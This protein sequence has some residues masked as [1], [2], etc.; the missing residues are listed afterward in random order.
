[1]LSGGRLIGFGAGDSGS[2]FLP[3]DIANLKA[4]Y[5]ADQGITISTGVSQW[6][7]LSG[8]ALHL[9]QGTGSNQ[10]TFDATGGP[11]STPTVKFDGSNDSLAV[12][13]TNVAQPYH[14]FAVF[15]TP[16]LANNLNGIITGAGTNERFFYNRTTNTMST[17]LNSGSVIL[18][19]THSDTSNYYLWEMKANSP[20]SSI[21]RGNG[22]PVTGDPGTQGISAIT[23]GRLVGQQYGACDIAEVIVYTALI[24]GTNATSIRAYFAARYGVTTQ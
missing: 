10:P 9:T 22:S 2:S 17:F 5:R 3:S 21:V 4:W 24:S 12:S 18:D 23:L 8:N 14:I 19:F 15:K 1:M 20:S 13:F 16:S 6:N 11:N 7:D